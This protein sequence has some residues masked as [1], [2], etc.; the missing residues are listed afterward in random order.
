MCHGQS[1]GRSYT[2]F[3]QGLCCCIRAAVMQGF[4]NLRIS[5]ASCKASN[6]ACDVSA[7]QRGMRH[8]LHCVQLM[9]SIIVHQ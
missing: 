7:A 1:S 2:L 3:S 9:L 4:S 8:C 6:T 5:R